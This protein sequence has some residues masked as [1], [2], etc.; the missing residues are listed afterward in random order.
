MQNSRTHVTLEY[1][2]LDNLFL[3]A[4]SITQNIRYTRIRITS[5]MLSEYI[6]MNEKIT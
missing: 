2:T 6:V 1:P 4:D 3:N 5:F